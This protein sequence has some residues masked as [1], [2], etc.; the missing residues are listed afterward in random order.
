MTILVRDRFSICYPEQMRF[1]KYYIVAAACSFAMGCPQAN[2]DDEHSAAWQS[3]DSHR[4]LTMSEGCQITQKPD[5]CLVEDGDVMVDCKG[6]YA[7]K[8]HLAEV[9]GRGAL[10][11]IRVTQSSQHVYVLYGDA[12][13]QVGRRNTRLHAGE[14]AV[15]ADSAFDAGERMR[16]DLIGRRR[17]R[18]VQVDETKALSVS[19]FSIVQ[20][21]EKEPAISRLFHSTDP[22]DKAAKEQLLKTAAVLNFVTG[23][24]GPYTHSLR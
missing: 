16:Q 14:E 13:V 6:G 24:H 17:L 19:E 21:V 23:T 1:L 22:R 15:V 12:T 5:E 8:S 3:I 7:I 4:K 20:A 18:M 10:L 9:N 11:F 2:A